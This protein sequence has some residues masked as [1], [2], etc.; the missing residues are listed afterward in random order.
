MKG[1]QCYEHVGGITLKITHLIIYLLPHFLS[2][3]KIM[4]TVRYITY[5]VIAMSTNI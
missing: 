2:S 5:L 4:L 3:C 1:A